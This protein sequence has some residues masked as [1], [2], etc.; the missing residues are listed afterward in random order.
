[1]YLKVLFVA[2]QKDS[3]RPIRTGEVA[4]T[5]GVSAASASEM[6]KRLGSKGLVNHVPYKGVTLTEQGINAASRVKRREALME[7]F[8]VK[9]LDYQGD[10]QKTACRLEHALTDELEESIDRML[11]YPKYS[12]DGSEIPPAN[13]TISVHSPSQLV[14]LSSLEDGE[15]A[16]VELLVLDGVDSKTLE[17]S[18]IE[19]GGIIMNSEGNL[20]I[21]GSQ[22]ILSDALTSRIM[23]RKQ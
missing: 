5:M 19:V 15:I 1:M 11:G 17:T 18:G 21:D 16:T 4:Q 7:V 23:V 20:D 9:M 22:I 8:L 3:E 10:I 2:H 14:P 13:R 6:L 12:P